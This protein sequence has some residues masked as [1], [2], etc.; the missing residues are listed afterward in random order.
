[1]DIPDSPRDDTPDGTSRRDLLKVAGAAALGLAGATRTAK[2]TTMPLIKNGRIKQSLVH[3]CYEPYWKDD[4]A[5]IQMAK[6]LGCT[7]VELAPPTMY[8]KLKAAG[9]TNAIAQIDISPDPPFTKGFNNPANWDRVIAATKKSIDD[10]AEYGYKKVI[11]FT[12]Y[13]EGISPE[14]GAA[15]CVEGFKKVVDYAGDKGVTLCLEMLNTRADDHPMKGHPGYQGDHVDY[16]IDIIKKVGSPHLKLLFDFYHV[17]IMD[18]DLIR[19]LHQLKGLVGHIHTA[20][21]PGRAE[22]DE[23]QEIFFPPLMQ[24]LLDIGYDGWVGHE[25]IPTRDPLEGLK[26]AVTL[27]DV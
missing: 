22:L 2:A 19:R 7:S 20:G 21:N 9:L 4:D 17:Q 27:C 11:C 23:K 1:M 18:G 5:F 8:P 6:D 16:C 24:A 12:G 3:W 13:A 10:C 26:Q 25:F 15:N 14:Q